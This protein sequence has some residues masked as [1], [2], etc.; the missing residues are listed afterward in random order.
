MRGYVFLRRS[1]LLL[2]PGIMPVL[3][4]VLVFIGC[5]ST[6][7]PARVAGQTLIPLSPAEADVNLTASYLSPE[8]LVALVG[9]NSNPFLFFAGSPL[10]VFRISVGRSERDIRLFYDS[11]G[12]RHA[13]GTRRPLPQSSITRYWDARLRKPR[14]SSVNDWISNRRQFTRWSSGKIT[15]NT[16]VFMVSSAQTI[17]ADEF[18]EGLVVFEGSLPTRGI[19]ILE[20][21][22]FSDTG[23]LTHNFSFEFQPYAGR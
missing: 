15:Y 18:Y 9:E 2:L 20:A 10:M 3:I 4:L 16:N 5:A 13:D 11:F 8:D 22:I 17:E 14:S 6:R 12:L 19:L 23:S 1:L 7:E 21:P